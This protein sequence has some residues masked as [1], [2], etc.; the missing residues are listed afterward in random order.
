MPL[1]DIGET[2]GGHTWAGGSSGSLKYSYRGVV[3]S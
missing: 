2:L 1:P 3:D